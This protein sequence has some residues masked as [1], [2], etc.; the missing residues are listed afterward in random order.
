MRREGP[1]HVVAGLVAK[2]D[3]A[4][5]ESEVEQDHADYCDGDSVEE[6]VAPLERHMEDEALDDEQEEDERQDG[7]QRGQGFDGGRFAVPRQRPGVWLGQSRQ[8]AAGQHEGGTE[9]A[10]DGE[11]RGERDDAEAGKRV[12]AA[13]GGCGQSDA[14][15]ED[16]RDG[17]RPGSDAAAV[18]GQPDDAVEPGLAGGVEGQREAGGNDGEDQRL[19]APAEHEAH[20]AEGDGQPDACRDSENEDVDPGAEQCLEYRGALG[21]HGGAGRLQRADGRLGEGGGGAEQGAEGEDEERA[22]ASGHREADVFGER[23]QAALDAFHETHQP[24][25]H[26]DDAEGD[27]FGLVERRA[28]RKCLEA[29]QHQCQRDNRAQLLGETHRDVGRHQTVEVNGAQP[30]TLLGQ[31]P[32]G[33]DHLGIGDLSMAAADGA[34]VLAVAKLSIGHCET[35]GCLTGFCHRHWVGAPLQARVSVRGGYRNT[36]RSDGS[37]R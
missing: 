30:R 8:A 36:R 6:Y 23:H 28:Q 14:D 33:R 35:D 18:P 31:R 22:G 2:L 20:Q 26:G 13:P 3:E 15:G 4:G 7:A 5:G 24:E 29:D 9:Y 16:E 19:Q 10:D 34:E 27:Q 37:R 17:D 1:G 25:H 32:L 11:Q 21:R 12:V